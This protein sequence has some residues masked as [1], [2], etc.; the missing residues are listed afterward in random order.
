MKKKSL[1]FVGVLIIFLAP[2]ILA[3]DSDYVLRSGDTV[4]G[5]LNI[6]NN[7]GVGTTSPGAKLD[8]QSVGNID[9]NP[10]LNLYA[11]PGDYYGAG[12]LI[13]STALNGGNKW[14]MHSAAGMAGEPLGSLVFYDYTTGAYGIVMNNVGN[15]GIGTTNPEAQLHVAGDAQIDGNIAAKFQ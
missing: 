13:D 12:M 3:A 2:L 1:L 5:G 4:I 9:N 15:V 10:Q 6:L 7:V 14:K 11:L 8:I